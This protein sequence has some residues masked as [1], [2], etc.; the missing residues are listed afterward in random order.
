MGWSWALFFCQAVVAAGMRL[1]G[2]EESDHIL[3]RAGTQVVSELNVKHALYVDNFA[4]ISGDAR[5]AKEIATA[6]RGILEAHG[7]GATRPPR[8]SASAS[9][10]GWHS[11]TGATSYA[12]LT[13]ASGAFA[14]HSSTL[15]RSP[16]SRASS[17]RASWDTSPGLR[18]YAGRRF[19]SLRRATAS[20][21]LPGLLARPPGS[22]CAESSSGCA[23]FYL[24]SGIGR[25]WGSRT[26][27]TP[28]T[29][30]TRATACALPDGHPIWSG[31]SAGRTSAGGSGPRT[32]STPGR[33]LF[34]RTS[35][36]STRRPW[37]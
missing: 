1:A 4:A 6:A 2:A 12:S 9:T 3:D 5:A 23:L 35:W 21:P 34:G 11:R 36:I 27:S 15:A 22:P 30:R 13:G 14:L 17:C 19:A 25:G 33:G 20:S 16:R 31:L 24:C 8:P 26:P 7:L 32:Q 37:P 18:C 10:P 28:A 29:R